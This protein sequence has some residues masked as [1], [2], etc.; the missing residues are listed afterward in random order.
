MSTSYDPYRITEKSAAALVKT[1]NA[2]ID[3]NNEISSSLYIFV[4]DQLI[5]N[6]MNHPKMDKNSRDYADLVA[7][8]K[9]AKDK[10]V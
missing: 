10:W 4:L 2:L 9:R 3:A 5:R 8:L 6:C 7:T 1:S